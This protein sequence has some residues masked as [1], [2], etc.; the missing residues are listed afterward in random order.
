MDDT[1]DRR[2]VDQKEGK[3]ELDGAPDAVATGQLP[4]EDE[5]HSSQVTQVFRVMRGDI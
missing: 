1:S 3:K 4:D 5:G 2:S